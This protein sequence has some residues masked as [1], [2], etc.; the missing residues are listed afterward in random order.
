ML[1]L[2]SAME[3]NG[4]TFASASPVT[5]T[6]AYKSLG[7]SS[8]NPLTFSNLDF[9]LATSNLICGAALY[10]CLE[11]SENPMASRDYSITFPPTPTC[12]EISCKGG[13]ISLIKDSAASLWNNLPSHIIS[14]DSTDQFKRA[15]KTHLFTIK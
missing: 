7:I 1:F 3:G 4:T 12:K 6:T 15:L 2:N 13:I 8:A 9:N 11:I 14:A 5:F 10:V